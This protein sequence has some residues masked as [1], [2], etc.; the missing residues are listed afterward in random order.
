[1]QDD[2]IGPKFFGLAA[3]DMA[4][5]VTNIFLVLNNLIGQLGLYIS[6]SNLP[7]LQGKLSVF[8]STFSF[9][10]CS[11][12]ISMIQTDGFIQP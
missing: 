11:S 6:T 2:H 5:I 7:C 8:I 12:S 9:Y 1:M 4:S 3:A 10:I